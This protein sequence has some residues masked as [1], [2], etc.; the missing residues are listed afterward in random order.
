M[1]S[2]AAIVANTLASTFPFKTPKRI[3]PTGISLSAASDFK[4][5]DDTVTLQICTSVTFNSLSTVDLLYLN[6][7]ISSGLSAGK[8][9]ALV[10]PAGVASSLTVS[11]RL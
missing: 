8:F 6:A 10:A 11:T 1:I 4:I 2:G 7:A 3:T 5:Y 9:T